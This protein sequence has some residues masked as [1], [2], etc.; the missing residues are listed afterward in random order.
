[1]T[2]LFLL[3]LAAVL[4]GFEIY[5]KRHMGKGFS[6]E[7]E[8]DKVLTEIDEPVQMTVRIANRRRLPVL[9]A[10]FSMS[11]PL[12]V[13]V[14]QERRAVISEEKLLDRPVGYIL[15]ETFYLMPRQTMKKT[16]T[17]SFSARGRYL[18]S[19]AALTTGDFLGTTEETTSFPFFEETVALPCRG[20]CPALDNAFGNFLGEISVQRFILPDPVL[21]VG[22]RE[23]TGREPMKEISWPR[24]LRDGRLMVKEFDHTAELSVAVILNIENALPETVEKCFSVTRSACEWLENKGVRYSF[25]SN[26]VT[27]NRTGN[28]SFLEDGHGRQHLY[29]VL[30]GL[31]RAPQQAVRCTFRELAGQAALHNDRQKGFIVITPAGDEAAQKEILLLERRLGQKVLA[32]PVEPG[33]T[34]C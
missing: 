15:S 19:S 31:G 33:E 24:S 25:C 29:T 11:L 28:W 8:F 20:D 32:V 9:F 13:N 3:L 30:E 22:F 18:F 16:Y 21:T 2:P 26:A 23:Y 10:R 5:S 17:V 14:R 7:V 27:A 12:T 6:V 34:P 4:A 1:M